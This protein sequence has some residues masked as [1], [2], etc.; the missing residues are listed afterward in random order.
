LIFASL[1]LFAVAFVGCSVSRERPALRSASAS[2][3]KPSRGSLNRC[4][5]RCRATGIAYAKL[6]ENALATKHYRRYL[7]LAPDAPDAQMVKALL[8]A[9]GR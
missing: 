6:R 4:E 9:G 2:T 7:E 1:G 3:K 8:D 5:N